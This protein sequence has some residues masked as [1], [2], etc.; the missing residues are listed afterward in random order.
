VFV[1]PTSIKLVTEVKKT[2]APVTGRTSKPAPNPPP[3]ANQGKNKL[4]N[5]L[6]EQQNN[7]IQGIKEEL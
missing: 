1:R 4:A 7:E 3:A 6:L 5:E 2:T